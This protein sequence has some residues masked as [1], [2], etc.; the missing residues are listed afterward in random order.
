LT[1]N[2]TDENAVPEAVEE[3]EASLDLSLFPVI[4][5]D[6]LKLDPSNARKHGS[7]DID[8]IAESLQGFGQQTPIVINR[9][10]V[11]VKGNGTVLAA[12]Q[13]GWETLHYIVTK[14]E[15]DEERAYAIADNQTALL[16]EWDI[17]ELSKQIQTFDESLLGKLGFSDADLAELIDANI[18]TFTVTD[19]PGG[20]IEPEDDTAFTV[21]LTEKVPDSDKGK[22]IEAI[23]KAMEGA[24]LAYRAEA[25]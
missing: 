22:V 24:G 7:K 10:G 21:Q 13:L 5:L 6:K 17:E 19:G 1:E 2:P 11:I 14:L 12:K 15:G 8:A 4:E 23:N 16:S 20:E 18:E 9:Y 25:Y 3:I